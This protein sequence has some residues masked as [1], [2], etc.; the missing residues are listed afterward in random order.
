[1]R[2][3]PGQIRN[4]T[5]SFQGCF[6]RNFCKFE[7]PMARPAVAPIRLNSVLLLVNVPN[8]E[9]EFADPFSFE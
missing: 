3:P 1:M 7:Q 8:I 5:V 4:Q 9:A 2:S 6:W